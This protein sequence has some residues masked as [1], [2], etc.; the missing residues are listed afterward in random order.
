MNI[1]EAV[2]ISIL[3]IAMLGLGY[4]AGY[5]Y[6]ALDQIRSERQTVTLGDPNADSNI[7]GYCGP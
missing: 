2:F 7:Q 1:S 5:Q 4:T 6:G 3:T